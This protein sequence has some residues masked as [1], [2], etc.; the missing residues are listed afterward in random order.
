MKK[1]LIVNLKK[2]FTDESIKRKKN[3]SQN[4]KLS[5]FFDSSKVNLFIPSFKRIKN[6]NFRF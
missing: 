4:F 3:F 5:K 2:K 6:G 1:V